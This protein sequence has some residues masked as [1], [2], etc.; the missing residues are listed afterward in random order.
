MKIL[1]ILTSKF[2]NTG[3]TKV[4]MNYY[5]ELIKNIDIQIDFVVPNKVDT[6]LAKPI[7]ENNGKMYFLPMKM[8][9]LLP[10]IYYLKLKRIIRKERYD[11]VHVHG[12]SAIMALELLIAKHAGVK[13]RI[14]HSHNTVTEHKILHKLLKRIFDMSYTDAF[15]CGKEAGRWLFKD[16]EFYIVKNAQDIEKFMFSEARR[17]EYRERYKLDNSIVLGHV[18]AF[19]FQK[20]HEFLIEMFNELHK[21][22]KRYQLVLIGTGPLYD[23]IKKKVSDYNLDENVTFVGNTTK[24]HE[25]LNAMDIMLLPSRYE[26]LPN[27]LV[28]WQI[29]G[30]PCV[31]SSTITKEVKLT[32]LVYF[33]ELNIEKWIDRISKISNN[34]SKR[35]INEI[36]IE[37][38]KKAGYDIKHNAKK[39]YQ[40]YKKLVKERE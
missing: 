31:I 25:W 12:S 13:T 39:L 16:K 5:N 2:H 21:K 17:K 24:V 15:A 22:D 7:L 40:V 27:V 19:N 4:I 23:E 14:A 34:L 6:E 20:N 28:E 37:N 3:I 29:A 11:I 35:M 9:R 30:L 32:K 8:R 18:G 26:G 1:M 38:I 36:D 10:I 33:E